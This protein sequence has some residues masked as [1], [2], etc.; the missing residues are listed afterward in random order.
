LRIDS[1]FR[2]GDEVTFFYDPLGATIQGMLDGLR[3]IVIDGP[4]TNF[5]FLIA[6]LSHAASKKG[7]GFHWFRK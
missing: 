7:T 5:A 2:D 6:T 4:A 1:G 3:Q